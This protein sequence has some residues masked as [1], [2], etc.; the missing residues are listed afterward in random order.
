M[1]T[2][3][4]LK[5]QSK[6]KTAL[7]VGA[8]VAAVAAAAGAGYYFYGDKNAKKHRA[9]A[10]KWTK[11]MKISVVKEAK[12]LKKIDQ[13]AMAK[14]VDAVAGAYQ[15]VRSVDTK[16]LKA[17]S[18]ELKKHWKNVQAEVSGAAKSARGSAKKAVGKAK[19]AA[20]KT[21]SAAK[22]TVKGATKKVAKKAPKKAMK[23]SR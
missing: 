1:A 17:A 5:K 8:G 18:A 15:G 10:K 6:T 21:V 20:K 2:K 23:R 3:K 7:E 22:K 9:A 4:A 13:K 16:D 19:K 11:D 12:K 14:V